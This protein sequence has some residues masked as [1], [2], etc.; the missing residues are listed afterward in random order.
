[1]DLAVKD[2][3]RHL[4][5]FLATI[6]GVGMLV[7]IVLIMN[8]IFQG[9]IAD[10]IWLID[11]TRADLWVVE[12]DR[13]GPFNESSRIPT[14][15]YRSV[16]AT[17][18]VAQASP[19]ISY[20]VQREIGGR[21]QQFTIIGYDVFGGLG[22]P[23][24]IV[25][26]RPIR[27]AHYELVADQ[28]LG[29]S[30]GQRVRLGIHD[31]TVVGVTR[32]AVDSGG[33]PLAYLSLPDAQEVLYQQDN[34][35]LDVQRARD[36]QRLEEAGYLP[37]EVNRLLPLLGGGSTTISA[38]LVVLEP[39]ADRAAVTRHIERWLYLSAYTTEQERDLM[40]E[41]KLKKMTAILGVFRTL[42]LIVAIVIIALLIYVL[43]MEKVRAIATLKIIGAGNSV[44]VRLILE[45]ALV[46]TLGSFAFGCA[47]TIATQDKFPRNLVLLPEETLLTFII[48]L[49]GGVVASMTGIWHAL[50]TPPSLALGG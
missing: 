22:G 11:N 18:G 14:D 45:Q 5:K 37:A 28:K 3:R 9:N 24:R 42:L 2:V 44:I 21:E 23:G 47:L 35:A 38:V 8:G 30:L 32:G 39:G 43:T 48:M 49:V 26:G 29:L 19:F 4:G 33:N 41:G 36:R 20:A 13:G 12:R 7:A 1:M 16:A 50:R 15:S 17:P 27:R 10:G 25:A 31:Y 46:L 40:L 6:A 34:R